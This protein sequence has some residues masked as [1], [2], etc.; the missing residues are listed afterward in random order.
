MDV[1]NSISKILKVIH[2]KQCI[3]ID[4]LNGPF[5]SLKVATLESL[6]IF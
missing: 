2:T 5:K 1:K 4:K 6:P 3:W